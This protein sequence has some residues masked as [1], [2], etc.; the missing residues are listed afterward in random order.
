MTDDTQLLLFNQD[1]EAALI[2]LAL[3]H[4]QEVINQSG[5]QAD[6]FYVHKYRFIFNA[7]ETLLARKVA[8]D[9]VS[10]CNELE[11]KDHLQDVGGGAGL[12][13]LVSSSPIGAKYDT[14][15]QIIKDFALRRK[16]LEVANDLARNVYNRSVPVQDTVA[17]AMDKLAKAPAANL[18]AQPYSYFAS[19]VYDDVVERSKNPAD[20]WGLQTHLIDFDHFTGGVQKSEV[21][22]LAGEPGIGKTKLMNQFGLTFAADGHPGAIFSLEMKG[23]ALARR[24]LS[25]S[26]KIPTR[27]L[28][29]GK[30]EENEWDK[31]TEAV[32]QS[33][34]LPLWICDYPLSVS[35]FRSQVT[36]LY[37]EHGIE[38]FALD[39]L[40][41][42]GGY[43]HQD[44]TER[45]ASLSR[46]V[47]NLVNELPVAGISV[48][49]VTKEVMDGGKPSKK[50]IRGSGQVVHDADVVAFLTDHIPDP[51]E[52]ANHDLA[53]LTFTKGRELD[54]GVQSI[55]L[56]VHKDYPGF[57]SVDTKTPV[58]AMVH[59]SWWQK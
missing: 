54:G 3:V 14:A 27:H 42:L 33:A 58:P 1:A 45:S 28:K 16:M 52:K 50:G 24:G 12:A 46:H 5:I 26:A 13:S 10:I 20:V 55:D 43:D 17:K 32:S 51:G 11:V 22:Y 31:F 36:R 9:I 53:T 39:Y 49:S 23:T 57:S 38:W 41:L 18:L 2:G 29:T 30:L 7:I 44:E 15:A 8:P 21:F 4:P 19:L 37:Y 56:L 6:D 25:L 34:L 35:D 47:K 59:E 40:L 48:N